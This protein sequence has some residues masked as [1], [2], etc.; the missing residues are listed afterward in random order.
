MKRDRVGKRWGRSRGTCFEEVAF[1][2][3]LT[4]AELARGKERKNGLG[5]G[6]CRHTEAGGA[7]RRR[8]RR[9]KG[10]GDRQR[11]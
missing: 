5:W 6:R 11:D 4:E 1:T 8:S 7:N 10:G 9:N 3:A 2:P